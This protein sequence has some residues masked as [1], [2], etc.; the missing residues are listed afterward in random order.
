VADIDHILTFYFIAMRITALLDSMQN[1]IYSLIK[2]LKP[3]RKNCPAQCHFCSFCEFWNSVKGQ[4]ESVARRRIISILN[5]QYTHHK[6]FRRLQGPITRRAVFA[7]PADCSSST[8]TSLSGSAGECVCAF[9]CVLTLLFHTFSI[10]A[11]PFYLFPAPQLRSNTFK[12]SFQ[13]Q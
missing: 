5:M 12:T 7:R 3:T 1:F 11:V 6:K 9:P 8:A 10:S 4:G 13:G 2:R